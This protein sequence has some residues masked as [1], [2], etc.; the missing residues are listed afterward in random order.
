VI[1]PFTKDAHSED[2]TKQ[3]ASEFFIELEKGDLVA[4]NGELGSGKTFFIKSVGEK[5]SIKNVNS[6]TFSLVNE[7]S[8]KVKMYHLDFY[9][10]KNVNELIDIGF[11]DYLNDNDAIIFIEWAGLFKQIL[12]AKRFEIN[13]KMKDDISREYRIEKYN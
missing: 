4:V 2:D 10:I 1:F 9:R 11:T 3:I 8:G 7:Y 5:F 13:I 6:P 12:P